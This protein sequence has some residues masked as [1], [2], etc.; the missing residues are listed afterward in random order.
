MLLLHELGI[1]ISIRECDGIYN[2]V[3]NF[4]AFLLRSEVGHAF[5]NLR[6]Q[7]DHLVGDP[8]PGYKKKIQIAFITC[9]EILNL[10]NMPQPT[11]R[12]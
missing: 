3:G 1:G 4:P 8:K 12:V 10:C 11:I 5:K 2:F 9:L 6:V 7:S